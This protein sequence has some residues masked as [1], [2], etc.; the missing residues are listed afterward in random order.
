M[1]VGAL[2]L[3]VALL[4]LWFG[5]MAAWG[6]AKALSARWLVAE[7]REGRGPAFSPDV[8]VQTRDQLRSAVQTTP[9]NPQL[10][11]DLGYLH[12]ARAQAMGVTEP[13]SIV[14]GYQLKLL[15][16]AIVQY[17]TAAQLRPTF[18]YSWAY[19]AMA[20]ELRGQP[21]DEMWLAFDKAM[22][23]GATE[24]AIRTVLAQIAFAHWKPLTPERK[25][26]IQ[27]ML[28]DTPLEPRQRLLDIAKLNAL[29][30][31]ELLQQVAP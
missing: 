24:S 13:G 16:E 23:F 11:D 1:A 12:A 8:W 30:P 22:H 18:P 10:Y 31:S 19:L 7:W 14:Q 28:A 9:D 29:L 21:D 5:G 15:D 6:D 27:R 20:K 17:R 26:A 4:S 3:V 2:A 25:A